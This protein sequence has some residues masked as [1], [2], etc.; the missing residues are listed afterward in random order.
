MLQEAE[1]RWAFLRS[2]QAPS[3][4]EGVEG[5]QGEVRFT[6]PTIAATPGVLPTPREVEQEGEGVPGRQ[7]GWMGRRCQPNRA[8]SRRRAGQGSQMVS[9]FHL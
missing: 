3:T 8:G 9:V 6:C 2:P 4:A 7:K 1:G 5:E